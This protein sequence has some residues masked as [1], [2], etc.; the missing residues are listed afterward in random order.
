MG[1]GLI[2]AKRSLEI[3]KK[4]MISRR[5]TTNKPKKK[6]MQMFLYQP[7]EQ[8]PKLHFSCDTLEHTDYGENMV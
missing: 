6:Y 7:G 3:Q 4:H 2:N 8:E 1:V 5:S